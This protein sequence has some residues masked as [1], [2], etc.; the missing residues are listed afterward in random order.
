VHTQTR[1]LDQGEGLTREAIALLLDVPADSF[2]VRVEPRLD[3]D[4]EA[5]VSAATEASEKARGAAEDASRPQREAARTLLARSY[6][7]D[8]AR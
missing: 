7:S 1:R 3:P 8:P 2:D 5:T 4:I 6:E